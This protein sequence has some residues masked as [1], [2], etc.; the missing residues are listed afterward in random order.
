MDGPMTKEALAILIKW[1][2]TDSV[3]FVK[4]ETEAF[5]AVRTYLI[6]KIFDMGTLPDLLLKRLETFY[7]NNTIDDKVLGEMR[8]LRWK[9]GDDELYELLVKQVAKKMV[10]LNWL[11]RQGEARDLQE[12]LFKQGK[13]SLMF[14]LKTQFLFQLAF[15][16]ECRKRMEEDT[17][18]GKGLGRGLIP[19]TERLDVMFRGVELLAK[20]DI[21]PSR[22][23]AAS[24]VSGVDEDPAKL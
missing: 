11:G 7:E 9:R 21:V 2:Y 18:N 1:M 5:V 3:H 22:G 4:D 15:N 23:S 16:K 19:Y 8:L 20:E 13:G 12:K 6:A 14:F 24:K 17:K 10:K